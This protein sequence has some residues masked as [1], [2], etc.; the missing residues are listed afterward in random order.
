MK[1]FIRFLLITVILFSSSLLFGQNPSD[2]DPLTERFYRLGFGVP[3]T[4]MDAPDLSMPDLSGTRVSLSDQK[5]KVVLL[6][7]WATWCPPC[8]AEMPAMEKVYRE[9][10]DE[11][12]TILAVSTRDARETRQ[13]VVE[14]INQEGYTFPV[15]FDETARAVPGFY[16]TGSIPT[17]YVIDKQGKVVAR[18]VGAFEWDSSAVVDL[19]RELSAQ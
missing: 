2:M 12:F 1:I 16:Q 14:Y 19:L 13:K 8:R 4:P 7:L 6:N 18:L 10:K 5:G 11:N 3:P 17:S 15:L 9:L